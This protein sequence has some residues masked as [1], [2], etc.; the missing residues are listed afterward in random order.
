MKEDMAT[1]PAKDV[2]SDDDIFFPSDVFEE[3]AGFR[4]PSPQPTIVSFARDSASVQPGSLTEFK[5]NL[6]G[7]HSLWAHWLWNAGKSMSN[8]LDKNKNM[9]AGKNVLEL[10]AAAALPTMICALNDA[11]KVVSTD[12]PDPALL[13]NIILNARENTPE[14]L[15]NNTIVVEGFIWGEDH[16][17]VLEHLS[18]DGSTKFDLILLADLIFNHNQHTNLLKSCREMLAP[19]GVVYTTFTH[20]VVKWAYRDMKFFETATEMGF[21]FEKIYQERWQCMFPEDDGDVD[22]RSTVHGYKMWV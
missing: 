15:E 8:Y 17:K 6:V 3:P 5:V 18:D 13:N 12:Y 20:H 1:E 14:F 21:K 9:V 11:K 7:K 22:V 19:G 10:G 4:P 2:P 16:T